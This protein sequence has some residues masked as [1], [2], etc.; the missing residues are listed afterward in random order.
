MPVQIVLADDHQVV[1]QGIKALLERDEAHKVIGEASNGWEAIRMTREL[2]PDVVVL[3][4]GMPVLNGLEAAREICVTSPKIPVIVFSRHS[5]DS[6]VLAALKA[7]V[8]GYVVKTQDSWDL[9]LAIREVVQG[10]FYVSPST[11]KAVVDAYFS[12]NATSGEVLTARER[13]V[14]Q[15]TVQGKTSNRIARILGIS[16]R[17]AES[18][19][20]R[21]R[22]KL[23][24][25]DTSGLVRY[26]VRQGLIEP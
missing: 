24:I 17:T 12:K 9:V 4:I 20:A 1:R 16:A 5:E 18:H 25:S 11:S 10:H 19:R 13:E 26:A 3:D 7:G 8:R 23:G 14:L 22:T 6:Y 15:L 21:I 2:K